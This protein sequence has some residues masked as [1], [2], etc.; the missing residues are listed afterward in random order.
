MAQTVRRG[1]INNIDLFL[2]NVVWQR[3]SYND[4]NDTVWQ[5]ITRNDT[6]LRMGS[7]AKEICDVYRGD[8]ALELLNSMAKAYPGD[9]FHERT[10]YQEM[11]LGFDV[12]SVC[13]HAPPMEMVNATVQH[14]APSLWHE[15]MLLVNDGGHRALIFA[16]MIAC[17]QISSIAIPV[18]WKN[19]RDENPFDKPDGFWDDRPYPA[20]PEFF[21]AKAHQQMNDMRW[22]RTDDDPP[23]FLS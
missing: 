9:W 1:L 16:L 19:V 8:T 11:A 22:E 15:K 12:E 10:S 13:K 2:Y 5:V 14:I 21:D 6:D 17:G 7:I 23:M 18:I 4:A 3:Y 20:V